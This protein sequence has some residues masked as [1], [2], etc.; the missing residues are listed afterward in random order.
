[1][2]SRLIFIT[3]LVSGAYLLAASSAGALTS[4]A[5]RDALAMRNLKPVA[6]FPASIPT[7]L[8]GADVRIS[9]EPGQPRAEYVVNWLRPKPGGGGALAG[10]M[11]LTRQPKSHLKDLI[12]SAK[13]R[14]SR[15]Y[16]STVGRLH[17][18]FVC[19]H[20]CGY[21]WVSGSKL[22][23]LFALYYGPSETTKDAMADARVIIRSLAPAR[24]EARPSASVASYSCGSM[25]VRGSYGT[26]FSGFRVSGSSCGTAAKVMR[27]RPAGTGV[28]YVLGWR[29]A[30][31]GYKFTGR[32][33]SA[34]F[35]C[36][37]YGAD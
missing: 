36:Y 4:V 13:G 10:W 9:Q 20:S 21:F 34:R 32:R 31:S 23:T 17:T 8:A 30:S 37:L 1:M 22:Y 29:V 14:G 7:R 3:L 6:L 2:R 24:R 35:S 19:L 28:R 33:G 12:A 27:A 18:R 25:T 15:I 16:E 26:G 11:Y 5:A